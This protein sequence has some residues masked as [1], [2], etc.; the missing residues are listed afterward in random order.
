M[1]NSINKRKLINTNLL[2]FHLKPIKN[3]KT[4]TFAFR[5]F[6]N[7]LNDENKQT[8]LTVREK[9]IESLDYKKIFKKKTFHKN[10]KVQDTLGQFKDFEERDITEMQQIMKKRLYA[11]DYL[12]IHDDWQK[13]LLKNKIRKGIIKY[14][15][16]N[17][18]T[19]K[20]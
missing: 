12:K 6:S 2:N 9:V 13:N 17:Y 7:S 8:E 18:V 19:F 10:F 15:Y 5:N 3:N 14:N 20:I 11:S 4:K 16:E 1:I